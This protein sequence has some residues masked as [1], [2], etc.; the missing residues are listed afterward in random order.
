MHFFETNKTYK[1]DSFII[2]RRKKM[3][4]YYLHEYRSS[5]KTKVI[6]WNHCAH[7]CS[8]IERL[9]VLLLSSNNIMKCFND[10]VIYVTSAKSYYIGI[11]KRC[12]ILNWLSLE[13]C[14]IYNCDVT[15]IVY[16]HCSLNVL[17]LLMT[18]FGG[19][20]GEYLIDVPQF[21]HQEIM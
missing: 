14:Q 16:A 4:I 9:I 1:Q 20:L 7:S 10:S 11:T 13:S 17:I 3:I 6:L 2:W 15:R 8:T 5:L 21:S 19:F 18:K 12:A